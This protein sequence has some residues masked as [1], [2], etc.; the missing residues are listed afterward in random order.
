MK[1]LA[2]KL[3]ASVTAATL[4]VSLI[5]SAPTAE[6]FS[7]G[8]AINI[9]QNGFGLYETGKRDISTTALIRLSRKLKVSSD[10]LIGLV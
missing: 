4:G 9:S 1:K 7:L 3:A 10:W 2:K 6:A 8:D 5:F